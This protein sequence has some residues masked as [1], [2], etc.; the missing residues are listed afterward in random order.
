MEA[1][2]KAQLE[3]LQATYTSR[4]KSTAELYKRLPE[5]L[6]ADGQFQALDEHASPEEVTARL[7]QIV[8]QQLASEQEHRFQALQQALAAKEADHV[9]L[10]SE[11]ASLAH[12]Q[13]DIGREHELRVAVA[14]GEAAAHHELVVRGAVDGG[15]DQ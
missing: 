6:R 1:I 5:V 7:V 14:V 15:V 10:A 11:L 12:S 13:Q 9:K 8:E 3:T 2:H 4:L